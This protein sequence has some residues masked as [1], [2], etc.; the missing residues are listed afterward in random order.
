MK[1]NTNSEPIKLLQL[2][3]LNANRSTGFSWERLNHAMS[4]ALSLA[5]GS[6]MEFYLNDFV[7]IQKTF[8]FHYWGT[9]SPIGTTGED[10]YA[11]AIKVNNTSAIQAYEEYAERGPYIMDSVSVGGTW[12]CHGGGT[13]KR[14]R[15]FMGCWVS[16]KGEQRKITSITKDYIIACAYHPKPEAKRCKKCRQYEYVYT[17]DKIKSRI[18]ITVKNIREHR[19]AEKAYKK[20]M[21][22]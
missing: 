6:G 17:R 14:S 21:G 22:S 3:W 4:E 13:R 8:R 19:A 15:V 11:N 2:V 1:K 12:Y 18:K 16:W 9:T 10:F 7:Y 20:E 5:I